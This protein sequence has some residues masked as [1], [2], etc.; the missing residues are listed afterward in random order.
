MNLFKVN[1]KDTRTTPL[2]TGKCSLRLWPFERLFS[3]FYPSLSWDGFIFSKIF[4]LLME[5]KGKVMGNY[6][7]NLKFTVSKIGYF[8]CNVMS[9]WFVL[10]NVLPLWFALKHVRRFKWWGC[11]VRSTSIFFSI[12]SN[13]PKKTIIKKLLS[14]S[15]YGIFKTKD[16]FI[17]TVT[18]RV[19]LTLYILKQT[20]SQKLLVILSMYDLLL[21]PTMSVKRRNCQG[22]K[23]SWI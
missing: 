5:N 21:L 2:T 7:F 13:R 3:L 9:H 20:F 8:I 1:N 19:V 15:E 17:T 18:K 12:M 23:L 11:L 16:K 14:T 10:F 6:L 4:I 22:K